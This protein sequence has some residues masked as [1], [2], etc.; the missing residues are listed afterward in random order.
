VSDVPT[1]VRGYDAREVVSALQKCIRRGLDDEAVYWAVELERSGLGAWCWKRL[2]V[3][4]SEDVGLAW[5]EGPAVI[6]ALHAGYLDLKRN[7]PRVPRQRPWRLCLVH[8]VLALARAPKSRLVDVAQIVAFRDDE[9]REVPDV[10]LDRHTVKGRRM[11]RGWDHF[12]TEGTQLVPHAEQPGEAAY[13]EQAMAA[14]ETIGPL[15][16]ADSPA[17]GSLFDEAPSDQP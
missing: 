1:T 3:I 13:R 9:R 14:V 12:W 2:R 15:P 7:A 17:Q 16:D 5:P 10:A 6:A 11:G 4:V 8:A